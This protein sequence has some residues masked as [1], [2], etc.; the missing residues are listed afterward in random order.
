[1]ITVEDVRRRMVE[2]EYD[3]RMNAACDWFLETEVI[4]KLWS[5]NPK[6]QFNTFLSFPEEFGYIDDKVFILCL[7]A[8]GFVVVNDY[9]LG[10][11]SYILS[12]GVSCPE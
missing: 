10:R 5:W 9:E 12:V 7:R 11:H 4:P 8:R 3:D 2:L 1:M 6:I